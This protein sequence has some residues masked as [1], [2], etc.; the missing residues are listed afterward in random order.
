MGKAWRYLEADGPLVDRLVAALRVPSPIARALVN[1]SHADE[2]SASR[3]LDPRLAGLN[4]PARLPAMAAAVQRIWKAVHGAETILV[5]GDYDVDGI[6][7]TALLAR[8]LRA[9]GGRVA[10]FIPH[11]IDHGY[12]LTCG[13]LRQAHERH[14][15]SLLIT[16]DCGTG[17]VEAVALARELGVDVIVTDHHEPPAEP[18]PAFALLNPKAGGSPDDQILA[19][20]GVAF[21]LAHALVKQGRSEGH[22]AAL[23]LDLRKYLYLV[24]LGTIAD[25][26]PLVGENRILAS[27][28]L[29][30]MN[31]DMPPGI[32][33]LCE[34]SG[35]REVLTTYHIG[36]LLGPRINAAGR[37]DSPETALELLLCDDFHAAMPLAAQ[38]QEANEERKLIEGEIEVQ[39]LRQVEES[40]DPDRVFAIVAA[41]RGW[42][43]GVVGIVASR[44]VGRFHRPSI[45]IGIDDAGKG[46]GSC[47]SIDGFD[48][49]GHLGE[50][51]AMLVRHGGHPMAAGTRDPGGPHRR[52]PRT[53]QPDRAAQ[54]AGTRPPARAQ[55]GRL[56]R[57]VG[58]RRGAHGADQPHDAVRALQSDAGLGLPGAQRGTRGRGRAQAPEDP[59]PPERPR[60]GSHRLRLCRART[61]GRAGGR[62]LPA[63][64][65]SLQRAGHPPDAGRGHP[66]RRSESV[67]GAALRPAA[68][69][70]GGVPSAWGWSHPVP[71]AGIPQQPGLCF[72]DKSLAPS[73]AQLYGARRVGASQPVFRDEFRGLRTPT[74]THDP[75][76]SYER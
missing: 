59:V 45:V 40:F 16:V 41:S 33:A 75:H 24:A 68:P 53:A 13:A 29:D 11:R 43:P 15:P 64:A 38:L 22:R 57:T 46:K 37:M 72:R 65:Q 31:R 69:R 47:R 60:P 54:P 25:M 56:A 71:S 39:A 30:Q 36:F 55:A 61:A 14:H 74:N 19:G 26:V 20:V 10:S 66:F 32:H 34:V 67:S 51:S 2:D 44:L 23:A 42:H 28:G 50:L 35:I 6:A 58:N 21:K 76:P 12:G 3:F 5:F 8:I 73:P 17:S 52:V 49:V 63:P 7:S 4:D 18:A 48:L 27:H 9:L 1:R 70:P 62:R